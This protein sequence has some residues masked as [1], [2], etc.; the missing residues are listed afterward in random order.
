MG[1]GAIKWLPLPPL[2][3]PPHPTPPHPAWP[4][5]GFGQSTKDREHRC[6]QLRRRPRAQRC[7]GERAAGP[8]AGPRA[9]GTRGGW[10]SPDAAEDP[11]APFAPLRRGKS[12]LGARRGGGAET[13]AAKARLTWA[14]RWSRA[15]QVSA[16]PALAEGAGGRRSCEPGCTWRGRGTPAAGPAPRS[17]PSPPRAPQARASLRLRPA[18]PAPSARGSR[19]PHRPHPV[20]SAA[21]HSFLF[22]TSTGNSASASSHPLSPRASAAPSAPNFPCRAPTSARKPRVAGSWAGTDL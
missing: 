16:P 2:P 12:S 22:D 19:L 8:R 3:S 11:G 10:A 7:A 4:G 1:P 15:R 5:S 9:A 21:L 17:S 13:W 18:G 6:Q 20:T 14:R